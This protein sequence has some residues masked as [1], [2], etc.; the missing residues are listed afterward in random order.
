MDA[1]NGLSYWSNRYLLI[2][3]MIDGILMRNESHP[4]PAGRPCPLRSSPFE[5]NG[6]VERTGEEKGQVTSLS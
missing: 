6:G 1:V 2:L 5:S 3:E 4:S